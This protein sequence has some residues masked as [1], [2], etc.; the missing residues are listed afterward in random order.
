MLRKILTPK[1]KVF[2]IDAK[3]FPESTQTLIPLEWV[4]RHGALPL[5]M[6]RKMVNVGFLDP[7]SSTD[8]AAIQELLQKKEIQR[9]E[10][11]AEQMLAVLSA[12]YGLSIDAIQN[13][14]SA[15]LHPKI[16]KLLEDFAHPAAVR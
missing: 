9:F 16:K 3:Y 14:A 8:V 5:G 1:F 15:D 6:K 7:Y 10:I 12:R 13:V 4:L 2:E 11:K